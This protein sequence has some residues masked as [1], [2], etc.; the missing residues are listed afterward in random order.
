MNWDKRARIIASAFH[1]GQST[2]LYALASSGAITED[3][4]RALRELREEDAPPDWTLDDAEALKWLHDYVVATGQREPVAR[5][6]DI[7]WT[8]EDEHEV[9]GQSKLP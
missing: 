1:D 5:W 4:E 9:F 7:Q 8:S 2:P 3:C 6:S